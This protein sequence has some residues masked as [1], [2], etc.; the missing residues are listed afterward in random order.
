MLTVQLVAKIIQTV[1]QLEDGQV[2]IYN[3]RR[4][5][6]NTK[7]LFVVVGMVDSTP[8]AVNLQNKGSTDEYRYTQMKETITIDLLSY[9]LSCPQRL[10]ELLGALHST[11]GEQLQEEYGFK[12][13]SVP[14]SVLNTSEVEGSSMIH[15]FTVT[16]VALRGYDN[17][18]PIEYFDTF[19]EETLTEEGVVLCLISP[20]L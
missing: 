19:S 17:S 4:T 11:Y 1:M 2:W 15:R 3:Q 6:P 9:D 5:I 12:L 18:S 7:G 20:M 13:A 14:Q 8:F 10:P 16:T